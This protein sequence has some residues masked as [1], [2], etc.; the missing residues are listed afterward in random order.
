[1]FWH[2]EADSAVL[3]RRDHDANVERCGAESF[4]F[5]RDPL[6][7][8]AAGDPLAPSEAIVFARRRRI[9]RRRTWTEAER[10]GAYGPSCGGG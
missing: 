9:R 1:M 3:A 7:I 10:S 8:G 6:Q 4:S 2:N 5:A